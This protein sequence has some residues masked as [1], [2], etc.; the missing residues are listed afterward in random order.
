M[1]GPDFQRSGN[2]IGLSLVKP[3]ETCLH[4]PAS[5]FPESKESGSPTLSS[6]QPQPDRGHLSLG[7]PAYPI[8]NLMGRAD[9][10]DQKPQGR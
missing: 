3:I 1:A 6:A 10:R 8:Q 4:L 7:E 2:T 5:F 9:Q